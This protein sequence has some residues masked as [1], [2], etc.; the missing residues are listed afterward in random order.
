MRSRMNLCLSVLLLMMS[1]TSA[2]AGQQQRCSSRMPTDDEAAA[3]EQD[4]S[5]NGRKS[6]DVI[7]VWVHVITRGSGYE[8]GEITAQMIREQI[9]VMN[10]G[11]TGALGGANTGFSFNL[12]GTTHTVNEEWFLMGYNSQAENRAK[13]ALRRG[14]AGTLNIYTIDGGL[15]LGWATF[16]KNYNGQADSDG[17]V[18]DYRSMPGGPYIRFGEGDTATHEVGHWL[19]LYHTFQNGCSKNGDYVTD[20]AAE[21]YPARGC[22]I[23]IDTCTKLAGIDPVTNF[24]DYS[25][26]PCLFDFTEGQAIRM[27]AAFATYRQ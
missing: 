21:R 17:I 8:N 15:Y 6:T 4:L 9:D 7:P 18:I 20:T 2:L 12:V 3:I 25:D 27:Q 5:N 19:G 26:D 1:A 16:P 10:D 24:M 22:P 13:K 23:G 14:D 11:F